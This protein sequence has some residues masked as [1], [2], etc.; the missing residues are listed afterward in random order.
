MEM[1]GIGGWCTVEVDHA[2]G[3]VARVFSNSSIFYFFSM[4]CILFVFG[5]VTRD[6]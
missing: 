1:F 5:H 4:L 3:H 6:S 2:V